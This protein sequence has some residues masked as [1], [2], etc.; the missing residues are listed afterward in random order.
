MYLTN[1]I[2]ENSVRE[3]ERLELRDKNALYDLGPN[4][5]LRSCTLVLKVPVRRLLWNGVKLI[6]CSVEVKRELRDL[7]SL[8]LWWSSSV[9][10]T[11]TRLYELGSSWLEAAGVEPAALDE[12]WTFSVGWALL[13][14][15][16]SI[17]PRNPG[18]VASW[19]GIDLWLSE[20]LP[21]R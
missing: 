9:T 4:F 8:L 1:V 11:S 10:W 16:T 18:N 15:L 14:N 19:T 6:A 13:I 12:F 21:R 2:L 7:G 20:T 3:H 5:I 17:Q